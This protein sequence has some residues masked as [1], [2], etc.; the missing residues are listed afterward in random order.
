MTIKDHGSI[1]SSKV[2]DTLSPCQPHS[3]GLYSSLSLEPE[4]ERERR[5]EERPLVQGCI[6][7]NIHSFNEQDKGLSPMGRIAPTLR[8]HQ[9]L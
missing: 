5:V 8:N 4:R 3:Q 1:F 2:H 7:A 9:I 6:H